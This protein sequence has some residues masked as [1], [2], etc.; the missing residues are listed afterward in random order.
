M[1]ISPTE[2]LLLVLQTPYLPVKVAALFLL[3]SFFFL[4][5][6]PPTEFYPLPLHAALPIFVVPLSFAKRRLWFRHRLEGLSATYNVPL[7]LRLS[8]PVDEAALWAAVQDV[9]ARHE[10]LRT[11]IGRAH[12]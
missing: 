9:V 6:P 2:S 5:D 3:S 12:V 1:S 11:E 7:A 4:N 10:S 8:G